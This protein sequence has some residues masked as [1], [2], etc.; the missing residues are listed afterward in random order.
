VE[1]TRISESYDYST[2]GIDYSKG[3]NQN[4]GGSHYVLATDEEFKKWTS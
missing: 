1:R 3:V 4:A 2:S